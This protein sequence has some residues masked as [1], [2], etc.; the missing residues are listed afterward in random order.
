MF[1]QLRRFLVLFR[2]TTFKE[3]SLIIIHQF[4]TK[5]LAQLNPV[6][7]RLLIFTVSCTD[8]NIHISRH[9]KELLLLDWKDD[10]KSVKFC[11][12]K[13]S[14]DL[15]VFTQIFI[16]DDFIQYTKPLQNLRLKE[17][18]FIIDAGA[19]IGCSALFFH[20]YFPRAKIICIEPEESNCKILR[21]NI[22]LNNASTQI[23]VLQKALWN[24]I[25]EL[26]LMQRDWSHDGFH[27]MQ[28]PVTDEI[29]AKIAT[30]TVPQL[31]QDFNFN[32][33]DLI[34]IDIE[35]AEKAI[36]E[37]ESHLKLFLPKTKSVIIEVHDEFIN[38]EVVFNKLSNY[39]FNCK[40]SFT[41]G[42]PPVIIAYKTE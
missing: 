19:N 7:H 20:L 27:V 15:L 38:E 1:K 34:K 36:F 5:K 32:Q 8:K 23:T 4:F 37:D 35:G 33:I 26:E 41:E 28:K 30:S 14:R 12:R 16:D 29:I 21:K 39:S 22:E 2:I 40:R 31:A 13:Y 3:F 25:T 10:E 6:L 17:F 11:V 42:Q 18:K 9:S 24:E